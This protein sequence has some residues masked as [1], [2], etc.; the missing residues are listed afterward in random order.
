MKPQWKKALLSGLSICL[1]ILLFG[2]L[3]NEPGATLYPP[4][5]FVRTFVFDTSS[6]WVYQ[7][8]GK[9]EIDSVYIIQSNRYFINLYGGRGSGSQKVLNVTMGLKN[10]DG[11]TQIFIAG[12]DGIPTYENK[13]IP[14]FSLSSFYNGGF[15]YVLGFDPRHG[16]PDPALWR[17]TMDQKPRFL[18]SA[19]IIQT[20]NGLIG[21][22]YTYAS[23]SAL[24]AR[25]PSVYK[26]TTWVKDVG[27][28]AYATRGGM[29]AGAM[30][31]EKQVVARVAKFVVWGQLWLWQQFF[32]IGIT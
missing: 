5:N 22:G 20:E 29:E 11:A 32:L 7:M 2:C 23:D 24:T 21:P 26:T 15:N 12:I 18:D 30:E 6:Y 16:D 8:K 28:S 25:F 14:P 27:L 10:I 4:E 1:S 19:Q 31:G 3:K 9:G 17:T 13:F